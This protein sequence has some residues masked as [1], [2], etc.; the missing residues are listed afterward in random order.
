MTNSSASNRGRV[1]RL[2]RAIRASLTGVDT[3]T[4]LAALFETCIFVASR[5][6][7]VRQKPAEL[8]AIPAQLL[9]RGR[10]RSFIVAA[11]PQLQAYVHGLVGYHTLDQIVSKCRRKFGASRTPSRSSV[12]RYLKHLE[13]L[14][15]AQR[16]GRK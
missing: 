11:D 6:P 5:M 9:R 1:Q 2:G 16:R 10:G 15:G 14:N 7:A 8:F 12:A 4:A 3:K 13:A